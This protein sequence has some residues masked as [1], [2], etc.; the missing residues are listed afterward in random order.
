MSFL[1]G[2]L[3]AVLGIG[4]II[5]IL[6]LIIINFI[7][8][9]IGRNKMNQLIYVAKNAKSIQEE[10]YT[11][12]KNVSGLTK[13]LEPEIIRDFPNFNKELLFSKI[14]SNLI[15]IFN[16]I[17]EKKIDNIK[18][19]ED[20]EYVYLNIK[21]KINELKLNYHTI[22]YDNVMFHNHAIKQYMKKQGVATITTSS[23]LEYYY[24]DTMSNNEK[25][26][27]KK[28][29]RYTCKFIYIYDENKIGKDKNIFSIRCPNCGA[30]LKG[31]GNYTCEYC[32]SHIEHLNLKVWKM[33]SYKEDYK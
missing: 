16:A 6:T 1:L 30:P 10:E 31:I 32:S 8:K 21:D 22:K 19:D 20:L 25:Q 18:N 2:L 28:Q 29:T 11:R 13:L 17:E 15:K 4:I 27:L 24:K 3:G 23:T 33:S 5:I 14:E 9:T 7:N 12:V 26:N